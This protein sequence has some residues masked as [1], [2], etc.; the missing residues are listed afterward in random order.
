MNGVS[1]PG[2]GTA[3][4]I[5]FNLLYFVSVVLL[6]SIS[7]ERVMNNASFVELPLNGKIYVGKNYLLRF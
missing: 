7:I 1:S 2:I 3:L 4:L 6:M 5:L